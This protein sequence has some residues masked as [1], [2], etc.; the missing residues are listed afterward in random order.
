M[1]NLRK[2]HKIALKT[3][4]LLVAFLSP[5]MDDMVQSQNGNQSHIQYDS[6]GT[7]LLMIWPM[8]MK[9]PS[10]QKK[11]NNTLDLWPLTFLNDLQIKQ[12]HKNNLY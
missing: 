5:G 7:L 2:S 3:Y 6:L 8:V 9:W 10:G 1:L 11:Q 12:G 4:Q